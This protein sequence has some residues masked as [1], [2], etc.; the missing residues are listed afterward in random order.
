MRALAPLAAILALSA[1]APAAGSTGPHDAVLNAFPPTERQA[2]VA[3]YPMDCRTRDAE[4]LC[5]TCTVMTLSAE[6]GFAVDAELYLHTL[7]ERDEALRI[8]ISAPLDR[9]DF[10][11]DGSPEGARA[12]M[13]GAHDWCRRQGGRRHAVMKDALD[14]ASGEIGR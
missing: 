12:A 6:Y 9:E 5:R 2:Y 14:E 7:R 1:C 13:D 4:T 3:N 10:G 8:A 11:H